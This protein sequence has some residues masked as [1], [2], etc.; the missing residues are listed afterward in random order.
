MGTAWLFAL[1][2]QPNTAQQVYQ[3]R[4]IAEAEAEADANVNVS[5]LKARVN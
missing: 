5:A 2:V 1:A 3:Q 4:S